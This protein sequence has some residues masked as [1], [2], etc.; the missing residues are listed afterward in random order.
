M[1]LVLEVSTVVA[2]ITEFLELGQDTST[3]INW[4][5]IIALFQVFKEVWD[6]WINVINFHIWIYNQQ[7]IWLS[8]LAN[9]FLSN[10]FPFSLVQFKILFFSYVDIILRTLLSGDDAV[11]N[12]M[13]V[14]CWEDK[15]VN[16]IFDKDDGNSRDFE[17]YI[18]VSSQP[19]YGM[20]LNRCVPACVTLGYRY[21]ALQV[22]SVYASF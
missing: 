17:V 4:E 18:A 16:T 12:K 9:Q 14:G 13:Y 11:W 5:K 2:E 6:V 10:I 3:S 20:T 7:S 22:S 1:T 19:W 21:A 8:G 15:N